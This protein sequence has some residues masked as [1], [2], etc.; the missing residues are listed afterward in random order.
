MLVLGL[1]AWKWTPVTTWVVGGLLLLLA[2]DWTWSAVDPSGWSELFRSSPCL[3][4]A[5]LAVILPIAVLGLRRPAVAGAMLVGSALISYAAFLSTI[6]GDTLAISSSLMTSRTVTIVPTLVIGALYL[7]GAAPDH[8][9]GQTAPDT[10]APDT[11]AAE[12]P[13]PTDK[14]TSAR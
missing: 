10:P 11:P 14:A 12:I 1:A 8:W 3:G 2:A 5:M 4:L 13:E 7:I 9:G 6:W